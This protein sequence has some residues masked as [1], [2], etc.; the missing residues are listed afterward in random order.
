MQRCTED[1]REGGMYLN[2][3]DQLILLHIQL[4]RDSDAVFLQD[5]P[6]AGVNTFTDQHGRDANRGHVHGCSPRVQGGS[7]ASDWG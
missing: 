5:G 7:L 6:T 1:T 3:R 2:L 4:L